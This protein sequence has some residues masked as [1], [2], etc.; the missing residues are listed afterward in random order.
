MKNYTHKLLFHCL[1]VFPHSTVHCF[2]RT[3][4]CNACCFRELEENPGSLVC[5]AT[6]LQ[7]NRD[8]SIAVVFLLVSTKMLWSQSAIKKYKFVNKI[9]L[10]NERVR[11]LH[12]IRLKKQ[13]LLLFTSLGFCQA[14]QE[15]R[16]TLKDQCLLVP[17]VIKDQ[18][19]SKEFSLQV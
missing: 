17:H 15:D 2:L 10:E 1:V 3:V 8:A 9:L 11:N 19:S 18:K 5:S 16:H 12:V 7:W 6:S 13:N 4:R 14:L